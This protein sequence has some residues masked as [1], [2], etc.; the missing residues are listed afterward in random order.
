MS[1][2][3]LPAARK[4]EIPRITRGEWAL[5]LVLVAIHFTHM[6]DFVIIMPLGKRLMDDFQ[7]TAPQFAWIISSYLLA[8]GFAS[9]L[10]TLVM[11]RFDRKSVLLTMYAGFG[12]STLL[13][14]LAPN[15]E[16]ML[17]AR[18]LAGVFGG[19]AAVAIMA[20]IGDVFPPEKRGRAT[21]AITAAFG[22]ASSVGLP[23]G[24]LLAEWFGRGAPFIALAVFSAVVWVIA[25]FRLPQVRAHLAHARRS[26]LKEFAA[27]A[28]EGNHQRAFVFSFFMVL[29]TFTVASFL[30]PYLM[31]LN[32]WSE[33]DLS[34]IYM[35]S[36][37]LTL[38]AMSLVG[39][40][41][42]RTGR[43]ALFRIL[44]GAALI[45]GLVL[46]NLPATPLWVAAIALSAFMVFAS[47][48]M[49]PAQAMLLG[50]A[51]PRMRGAF[52]SLNT[53]VQHLATGIAP[54]LAGALI[55]KGD[56][57]KITGFPLVGLVAAAAALISMALA[58][59]L[60]MASI[61]LPTPGPRGDVDVPE[62]SSLRAS[63]P[64]PI[65]ASR[66]SGSV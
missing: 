32:G 63:V 16:W 46:T 35:I 2:A 12:I 27:V 22:V 61:Q 44:A 1:D 50:A 15:Y 13:C 3:N 36:G 24:L 17:I 21:G 25:S 49:V 23:A 65:T 51:E 53:A 56:D 66:K 7:I 55:V 37:F 54:V 38:I 47:G 9:L 64:I 6:V 33:G 18:T 14:G 59:R 41:A 62:A 40:L 42:D 4:P 20:V 34:W 10:A 48:R 31:G 19:L 39:R 57:G 58:G 11:D 60:R 26:P 43:L 30:A 52:M 5:I 8:A 29:G 45:L 28:K